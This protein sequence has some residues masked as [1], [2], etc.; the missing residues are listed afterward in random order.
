MDATP[1][2]RLRLGI[3]P[4]PVAGAGRPLDE[5]ALPSRLVDILPDGTEQFSQCGA[6]RSAPF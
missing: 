4:P 5:F 6:V 2:K 1:T 3:E